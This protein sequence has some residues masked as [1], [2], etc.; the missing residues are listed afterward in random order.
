MTLGKLN[1]ELFKRGIA[2][3][4][5]KND[6]IACL[7]A[8][9]DG[10]NLK[11]PK[12][13]PL[14]VYRSNIVFSTAT[15]KYID[16]EKPFRGI[17]KDLVYLILQMLDLRSLVAIAMTSATYY[18]VVYKILFP[19]F[20]AL[21][22]EYQ[23]RI[24]DTAHWRIQ[25]NEKDGIREIMKS[26]KGITP[27]A[28]FYLSRM[29]LKLRGAIKWTQQDSK[30]SAFKDLSSIVSRRFGGSRSNRFCEHIFDVLRKIHESGTLDIFFQKRDTVRNR[31]S[32]LKNLAQERIDIMYEK[33]AKAGYHIDNGA[34]RLRG[35]GKGFGVHLGGVCLR[36]DDYC[37]PE[38]WKWDGH[39]KSKEFG[40]TKRA[41]V[42]Y[43]QNDMPFDWSMLEHHL[44]MFANYATTTIRKLE[45]KVIINVKRR[46]IEE[47]PK[48]E[49]STQ[50]FFTGWI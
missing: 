50:D 29:R 47:E 39:T 5:R 35:S 30:F 6:A 41:F 38:Q 11:M 18:A 32:H 33:I 25:D 26:G 37:P 34:L 16:T 31:L 36:D 20:L 48:S 12:S 7:E 13:V 42:N 1:N 23:G 27:F 4:V 22:K 2:N 43:L 3:A 44:D 49:P 10:M 15:T 9:D 45:C 46:R 40:D 8:D 19:V 24:T 21:F 28:L 17:P 14:T